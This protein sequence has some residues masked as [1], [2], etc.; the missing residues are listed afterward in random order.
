LNNKKHLIESAIL[1]A[2]IFLKGQK[3][4]LN[5]QGLNRSCG[6]RY[7]YILMKPIEID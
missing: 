7:T 5:T 6:R 2:K 1:G 4:H 3:K